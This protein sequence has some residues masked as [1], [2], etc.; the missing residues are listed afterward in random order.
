[1]PHL[2]KVLKKAYDIYLTRDD[3]PTSSLSKFTDFLVK[4]RLL[5][6]DSSEMES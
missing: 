3:F 6:D 5:S 4:I 2:Y 1:M